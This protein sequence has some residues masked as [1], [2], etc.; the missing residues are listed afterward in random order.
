MAPDPLGVTAT[1][2]QNATVQA[3]NGMTN[4]FS[5]EMRPVNELHTVSTLRIPASLFYYDLP[6]Q[7]CQTVRPRIFTTKSITYS[8]L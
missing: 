7:L 1:I 5:N 2:N 8:D 6:H 3:I 4:A